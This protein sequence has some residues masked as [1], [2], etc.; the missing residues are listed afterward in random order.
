MGCV[1]WRCDFVKCSNRD[2]CDNILCIR[3]LRHDCDK[4]TLRDM[5]VAYQNLD[6]TLKEKVKYESEKNK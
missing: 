1:L 2:L 5:C 4:C 6:S 3:F